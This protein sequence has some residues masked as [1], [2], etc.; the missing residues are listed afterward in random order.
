LWR[1]DREKKLGRKGGEDKDLFSEKEK[2]KKRQKKGK[3]YELF[4][5]ERKENHLSLKKVGE[6]KKKQKNTRPQKG[7]GGV[8]IYTQMTHKKDKEGHY[9]HR[10][11]GMKSGEKRGGGVKGGSGR[12]QQLW[13][14]GKKRR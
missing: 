8:L 5:Y 11:G 14:R 3:K 1:R 7:E 6:L 10:E 4:N 13:E 12:L 9:Q 2:L